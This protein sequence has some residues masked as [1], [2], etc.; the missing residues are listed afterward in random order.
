[1]LSSESY[2]S[3]H[4]LAQWTKLS[5]Q[6]NVAFY[7]LGSHPAWIP[8]EEIASSRYFWLTWVRM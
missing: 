2:W 5:V 8:S 6:R 3:S 4:C 7:Y 1:M